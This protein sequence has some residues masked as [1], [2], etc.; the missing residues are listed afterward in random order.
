[1]VLRAVLAF[2]LLAATVGAQ[3]I[4]RR[5]RVHR[6]AIRATKV[7]DLCSLPGTMFFDA[8]Y[9]DG[10]SRPIDAAACGIDPPSWGVERYVDMDRDGFRIIVRDLEF[11]DEFP[12]SIAVS[13][14]ENVHLYERV[15]RY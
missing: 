5:C 12:M 2:V 9:F 4:P 14:G 8:R 10:R 3:D 7:A 11:G 6:I 15:Y 13:Q 1:M